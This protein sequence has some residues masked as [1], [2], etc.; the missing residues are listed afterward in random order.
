MTTLHEDIENQR[1]AAARGDGARKILESDLWLE[2]WAIYESRIMT[3]F[4]S[5]KSD[6][7]SRLQQLKMLHLAGAAARA[8]LESIIAD[9]KFATQDLAFKEKRGIL[10]LFK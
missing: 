9:G 3:E 10:R 2:C 4:A 8:H 5:C 7:V 1:I 6:D